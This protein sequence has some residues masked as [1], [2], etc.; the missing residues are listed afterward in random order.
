ML[1]L[2]WLESRNIFINLLYAI[3]NN[4]NEIKNFFKPIFNK[5]LF[6]IVDK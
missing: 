3:N 5:I 1:L 2:R 4:I 6:S